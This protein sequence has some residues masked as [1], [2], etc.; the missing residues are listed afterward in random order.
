M[1]NLIPVTV[2]IKA[3]SYLV[4]LLFTS[5][6]HFW[7]ISFRPQLPGEVFCVLWSS[8]TIR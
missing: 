6:L 8:D 7:A 1:M 5:S 3:A 2:V 4:F